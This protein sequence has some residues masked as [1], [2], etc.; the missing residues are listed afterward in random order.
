MELAMERD[1]SIEGL[2]ILIVKGQLIP[3]TTPL[4]RHY[5]TELITK[6]GPWLLVDMEEVDV[7]GSTARRVLVA[8]REATTANGGF[9][10][11]IR[12]PRLW[13]AREDGFQTFE[14]RAQALEELARHGPGQLP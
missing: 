4:L 11:L 12:P 10:C 5:L 2:T 3:F 6:N 8:A 14:S 7:V 13:N 9:L 1:T